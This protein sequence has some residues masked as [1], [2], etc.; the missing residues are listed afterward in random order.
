MPKAD[1]KHYYIYFI[2][3]GNPFKRIFKIGTTNDLLRRMKE[4]SRNYGTDD[5]K[6]DIA[7]I[8]FKKVKSKWTTLRIDFV[9]SQVVQEHREICFDCQA[10]V[11]EKVLNLLNEITIIGDKNDE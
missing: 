7:I 9:G 11:R 4:H 2:Q 6:E 10:E 5:Q 8:W 1:G 3:V